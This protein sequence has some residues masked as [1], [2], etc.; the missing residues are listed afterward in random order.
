[1]LGEPIAV[2]PQLLGVPR[3]VERVAERK[4]GVAPAEDRRKVEDGKGNTAGGHLHR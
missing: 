1:M 3:E 2:V 4:R